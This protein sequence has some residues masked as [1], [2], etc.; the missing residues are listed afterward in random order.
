MID[1]KALA[2]EIKDE[3][4][5]EVDD[6]I[7]KGNRPPHLSVVQVGDDPA[8]SLYIKNKITATKY[9]G[10]SHTCKRGKNTGFSKY[11]ICL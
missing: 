7:A 4:K 11:G 6:I 2:K 5:E 1:C 8:S 9:T 10:E 3:V